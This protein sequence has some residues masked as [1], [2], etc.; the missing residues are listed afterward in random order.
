MNFINNE[1]I[2]FESNGVQGH[3]IILADSPD[4]PNNP[5]IGL[6]AHL[7]DPHSNSAPANLEP[8]N[9]QNQNMA[10][11]LQRQRSNYANSNNLQRPNHN[12]D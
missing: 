11:P 6:P 2:D 7:Q 3:I 9:I 10:S 12:N 1:Q 4:G 8:R 5:D